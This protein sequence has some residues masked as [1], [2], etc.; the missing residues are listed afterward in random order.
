MITIPVKVC[1]DHWLN[2]EEVSEQL[3][4]AHN[5]DVVLDLHAEGPSLRALGVTDVIDAANIDP[6]RVYVANW[7]NML[8][9][10]AFARLHQPRIS[11][12]FW[13]SEKYSMGNI[14]ADAGAKTLACF[15]GRITIPR[16]V[17]LWDLQTRLQDHCL[18]SLMHGHGT[19]RETIDTWQ[20]WLPDT[21]DDFDLWWQGRNITS[22][23]QH[24]VQHQYQQ[25]YNTN[26]DILE[27]YTKFK[28]EVV[29]ETYTRGETFFPTE[30]TVR[31]LSAGKPL[32]VH[33][34][35]NFLKNLRNLG[36]RTWNH[37]WDESYDQLEGAAR[38]AAM[39]DVIQ[40]VCERRHIE[41]E[42]VEI[43]AHNIE[44]LKNLIGKHR[45]GP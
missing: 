29:A 39:L 13:M 8:E 15:V 1:G 22:L 43:A 45:P 41:H 33:G 21:R 32:L 5:H 37:V 42:C 25:G 7:H 19:P 3:G 4:Q 14:K 28:I 40:Y 34:P 38:W 30:K 9:N 2:P 35:R 18:V 36:F 16:A 31:P 24:W 12:F 11:H 23:D 10:C 26:R 27:H 20:E 6:R 17:M 44:H